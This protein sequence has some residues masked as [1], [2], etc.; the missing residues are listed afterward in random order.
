VLRDPVVDVNE[1][2][3]RRPRENAGVVERAAVELHVRE[4]LEEHVVRLGV[5]V[6]EL[7]PGQDR[8]MLAGEAST[9]SPTTIPRCS[10]AH[11]VDT[12]MDRRRSR[13]ARNRQS[14]WPPQPPRRGPFSEEAPLPPL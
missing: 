12:L 5:G 11:P 6:L 14:P 3:E 13:R 9:S 10:R 2:L 1:V 7:L 8:S 4:V